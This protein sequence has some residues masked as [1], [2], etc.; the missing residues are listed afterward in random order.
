MLTTIPEPPTR[1]FDCLNIGAARVAWT[2]RFAFSIGG[3]AD[4]TQLMKLEGIDAAGVV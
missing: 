4:C 2:E 3:N 1:N